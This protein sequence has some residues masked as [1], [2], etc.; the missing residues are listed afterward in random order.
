MTLYVGLRNYTDIK[1]GLRVRKD[2]PV[3]LSDADAA[4]LPSDVIGPASDLVAQPTVSP[5][6][7]ERGPEMVTFGPE[8]DIKIDLGADELSQ[9][10]NRKRTA[11]K[12]RT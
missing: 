5:L 2:E 1:S 8:P 7:G 4:R 6:V 3:E 12:D 11:Q 10:P 9:K